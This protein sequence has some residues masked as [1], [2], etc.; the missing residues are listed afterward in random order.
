MDRVKV[1]LIVDRHRVKAGKRVTL[2]VQFHLR[3]GRELATFLRDLVT[4]FRLQ[5]QITLAL[6]RSQITGF[7]Q[8]INV[9]KILIRIS[10]PILLTG[11][12][13]AGIL[14]IRISDKSLLRQPNLTPSTGE[15]LLNGIK[16][17]LIF[18][19]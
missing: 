8:L 10:Q 16:T 1:P 6:S 9:G 5:I 7:Q 14:I 11:H 3:P 17:A 2:N 19:G 15:K 18:L 13:I 4:Q 12:R